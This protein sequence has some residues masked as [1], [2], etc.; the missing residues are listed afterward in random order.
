MFKKFKDKLA[1]EVKSSPQRIQ[2]FAQAAQAA[3]TSASSSISDITNNDLFSIGDN[4]IPNKN[5][6]NPNNMDNLVIPNPIPAVQNSTPAMQS[7]SD[8]ADFSVN[9]ED[10]HRQRRLSNSSFAS[11]ISFRLPNYESPSMY[12]LQSDM[13]VSAS[14]AEEKGFTIGN[15]NLDRVTKDQLYAA[16][17]RTQD[18]CK[19]YKTQ[20][21][22]LARHYKLLERENA[23][24]RNV[25]VET[26][27]KALRRISE[28]KE[29][30]S[31]EQ[32][33]KAH[34]EKALRVEIEEK[35]MKI[36]AL[37]TQLNLLQ[38]NNFQENT[39]ST[40]MQENALLP[41]INLNDE[42]ESKDK[43]REEE[44]VSVIN[45]TI[46]KLEKLLAKY[47]ESLKTVKEKNSNMT[48]EIQKL[49][50]DLEA[51]C[52]EN[53]QLQLNIEKLSESKNQVQELLE[54]IESLE[55]I[56]NTLEFSKTKETSILESNLHNA[57]EEITQL[58]KKVQILSKREEEY[59]I[60]L[61]ENKLS[62][63]KEL[64]S[65][66][67][68]IKSLKDSLANSQNEIISLNK[69]VKD[70]Q[71][72]IYKLEGEHSK[73]TNDLHNLN[74]AITKTE[75][76]NKDLEKLND[77]VRL[78]ESVKTKSEE[79][80]NCLHL[81]LKQETAE[82][83]SVIDRNV[84]LESRNSQ[85]TE[86]NEKKR[87]Q[88]NNLE[89]EI[90]SLKQHLEDFKKSIEERNQNN[91]ESHQLRL[92]EE[93]SAWKL[94]CSSLESEIQEER[95]ELV[96][97][98]SEIEKLLNNHESLQNQNIDLNKTLDNFKVENVTLHQKIDVY[99]KIHYK[100]KDF[101]K[102][103][104]D[105][106]NIA[107][108]T[109]TESKLLNKKVL[110]EWL[111]QIKESINS[112]IFQ[113]DANKIQQNNAQLK[114]E[115]AKITNDY[116]LLKDNA[117]V[118][119]KES[120]SLNDTLKSRVLENTILTE[121]VQNMK[122]KHKNYVLEM[123]NKF[124]SL[125]EDNVGLD[126]KV[127]TLE[128][129]IIAINEELNIVKN[130][131]QHQKIIIDSLMAENN[132]VSKIRKENSEKQ[133]YISELESKLQIQEE[134]NGNLKLLQVELDNKKKTLEIQLSEVLTTHHDT[135][136]NLKMLEKENKELKFSIAEIEKHSKNVESK[137]V[138]LQKC[139]IDL[140]SNL[141]ELKK[142]NNELMY[143]KKDMEEKHKILLDKVESNS[144]EMDK[145]VQ[146]I[147][148]NY[149]ELKTIHAETENKYKMAENEIHELHNVHSEIIKQ[150]ENLEET[151]LKLEN[152]VANQIQ[153]IKELNED[154]KLQKG[155]KSECDFLKDE[156]RRLC[157]DI[158]GLQTYLSKISKE[159]SDL[160]DKLR[161]LIASS[162]NMPDG[163]EQLK[164]E[165]QL[166]KEKI[167]E[168][169]RENSL[170][171]EENLE[172]KDQIQSQITSTTDIQ[173]NQNRSTNENCN[174]L[175]DIH[176]KYY[177]LMENK[178]KLEL[179]VNE[180][181]QMN[182]SLNKNVDQTQNNYERLK[183]S[184]EKLQRKLDEALV[185][186]RHLHALEENTELEYLRNILYEY[187][188]GSGT[189]SLTLAKVLAAVV[190]F[191]DRQTEQILQKEKERQGFLHQLGII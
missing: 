42:N 89:H 54:K 94:K 99:Q 39:K 1:E 30:C 90:V 188:T 16:Y 29:Q 56:N 174:E 76:L 46:E 17:R 73:L 75:D 81:Q 169:L 106:Q 191:D 189:H 98:Q 128:T 83:L 13:E 133:D 64:E 135:E 5:Q 176:E 181:E 4:D 49:T 87:S 36:D 108:L 40:T 164:N 67:A 14:E 9:F 24:A 28:L 167:D 91:L 150:K 117:N 47:K 70:Y 160:N 148:Q 38:S 61:A 149:Q 63:H 84:Y 171:I 180:L 118:L 124:K 126:T 33:A 119:Q 95:V 172:L 58:Q 140:E 79:D 111:P 69:S 92:T 57:K 74:V 143:S 145:N 103:L 32:S 3:V 48:A 53:N 25:L 110:T 147:N 6:T 144:L 104:S 146:T 123:E 23:K 139:Q 50:L 137:L 12:H 88:I 8:V 130:E 190:K 162:D 65:K 121:K 7:A 154:I 129:T 168:L 166:G 131:N 59:A 86:D 179:K 101:K 173:L 163:N 62:I 170:L 93:V 120:L 60:S 187:L 114:E 138:E 2:Q 136:N 141:K 156:N 158:E 175:K 52:K 115:I 68:E 102:E 22:D 72:Q 151:V 51:K 159:N 97:L 77:K 27:D 155:K 21:S 26:Q 182:N 44:N 153:Q 152:D 43:T 161:E 142:E 78:L 105:I 19:K 183:L 96:K 45:N 165:I 132:E 177:S 80:I 134:K 31:L 37:S 71:N 41:L 109:S 35:Q 20:Y 186:L 85:L 10:K 107:T 184:N 113:Q 11:D 127:K 66:E 178:N 185:S 157:S 100:L 116:K 18:R 122:I 82:K 55:N 125:E 15:V 112:S 34:L